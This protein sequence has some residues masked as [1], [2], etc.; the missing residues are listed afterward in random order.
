VLAGALVLPVAGTVGGALGS[1]VGNFGYLAYFSLRD[2]G[3]VTRTRTSFVILPSDPYLMPN[4]WRSIWSGT[5]R[6]G[7]IPE[8]LSK[9]RIWSAGSLYRLR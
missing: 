2:P 3:F 9:R 6:S 8:H 4:V 5:A 1:L 7:S